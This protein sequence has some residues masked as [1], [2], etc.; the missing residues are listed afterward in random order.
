MQALLLGMQ[1]TNTKVYSSADVT[2]VVNTL[3]AEKVPGLPATFEQVFSV[4]QNAG[5]LLYIHGGCVRDFLIGLSPKDIDIE[6]SFVVTT[7]LYNAC[8]RAHSASS[9]HFYKGSSDFYVGEN[10][11]FSQFEELEGVNWNG[12]IFALPL[13]KSILLM[14]FHLI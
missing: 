2:A 14:H 6:Y 4:F 7:T 11:G 3:K 13:L 12:T 9:C 10:E 5:C 8:I 1:N